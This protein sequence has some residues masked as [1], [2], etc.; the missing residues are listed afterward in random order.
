MPSALKS[1]LRSLGQLIGSTVQEGRNK[2]GALEAGFLPLARP[3]LWR[4]VQK[5]YQN[6]AH[7]RAGLSSGLQ[8]KLDR[9]PQRIQFGIQSNQSW[10]QRNDHPTK[11]PTT[12][13]TILT[14]GP[15]FERLMAMLRDRQG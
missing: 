1:R 9:L 3:E 10:A 12:T 11:G 5:S 4:G 13:E 7:P 15:E 6:A 8:S 2:L 14:E